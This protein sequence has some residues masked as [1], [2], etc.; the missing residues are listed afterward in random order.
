M[1]QILTGHFEADGDAHNLVLGTVPTHLRVINVNAAEDE[2]FEI[3]WFSEMGDN[4]EIWKYLVAGHTNIVYK[5]SGGYISDYNT[6]S[7]QTSDPV[8][9]TGGKGVTI[10][11][12]FMDDGDEIYYYATTASRDVDHGDIA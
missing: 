5:S 2:V 4:V 7:Y 9:A 1:S 6:A 12:A 3:E 11:A 10:A 8:M